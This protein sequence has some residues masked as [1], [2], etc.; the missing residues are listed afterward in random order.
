MKGYICRVSRWP[1]RLLELLISQGFT[2][3]ASQI[4]LVSPGV[5]IL[6]NI[7]GLPLLCTSIHLLFDILRLQFIWLRKKGCTDR[8]EC[9]RPPRICVCV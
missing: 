2:S 8:P 3:E 7:K 5:P 4:E 1:S 9:F 6:S